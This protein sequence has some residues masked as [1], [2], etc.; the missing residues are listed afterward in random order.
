MPRASPARLVWAQSGSTDPASLAVCRG[1]KFLLCTYLAALLPCLV[2]LYQPRI[3]ETCGKTSVRL[4]TAPRIETAVLEPTSQ[5]LSRFRGRKRT[6][7]SRNRSNVLQ[8]L[9][10]TLSVAAHD[11]I[12]SGSCRVGDTS[13]VPAK[14]PSRIFFPRCLDAS[15]F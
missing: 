9:W 8:G 14:K 15:E 7:L 13:R 10:H 5:W 2:T 11:P 4:S 6:V 12:T 1:L 3:S